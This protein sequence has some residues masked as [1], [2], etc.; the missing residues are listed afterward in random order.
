MASDE[1]LNDEQMT[2]ALELMALVKEAG[3]DLSP[4]R[5]ELIMPGHP[6]GK[7]RVSSFRSHASFKHF[8][9]FAIQARRR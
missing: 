2:V 9:L 8:L 6:M 7:V 1:P 5:S 4:D 3:F